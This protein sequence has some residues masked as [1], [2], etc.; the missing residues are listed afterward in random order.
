M[1]MTPRVLGFGGFFF[2]S[3]DPDGLA[4]WYDRA[5]GISQV[6]ETEG[7][8]PWVAD[9]GPVAF[10]PFPKDTD[11]FGDARYSF[12]LNFRVADL[13]AMVAHL[14]AMGVAVEVDPEAYS[15]GRFAQLADPEGNPIQLWQPES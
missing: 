1:T 14:R 2:R 13:D 7:G 6:P 5:L 4:A 3:E 10:T 15:Y 9:A 12:M 11:V 8:D